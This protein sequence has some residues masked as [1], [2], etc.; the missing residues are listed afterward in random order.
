M[1]WQVTFL[2]VMAALG[3]KQFI[4][5]LMPRWVRFPQLASLALAYGVVVAVVA[6]LRG[7]V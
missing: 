2:L 4:D 7:A 5:P 3:V 1:F 6:S